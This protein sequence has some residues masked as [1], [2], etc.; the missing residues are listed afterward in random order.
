MSRWIERLPDGGY[1][2][3]LADPDECRHMYNE[4][5]CHEDSPC[6][7]DYPGYEYCRQC[8]LF[9]SKEEAV[10]RITGSRGE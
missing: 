10:K 7:A 2:D 3:T 5:C 9:E 6:L 1:K 8:K 4:V